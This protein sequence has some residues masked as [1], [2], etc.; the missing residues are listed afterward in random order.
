MIRTKF[1]KKSVIAFSVVALLSGCANKMQDTNTEKTKQGAL[2]GAVA[3][4]VLAAATGEGNRAKRAA[5]G[6]AAGAAV[7]GAIGYNMDKQAK[8]IAKS[9]DTDVSTSVEAEK[10]KDLDII[11]T[12]TDNYVKVTFR[13]KMM[14]ETNSATPTQ[15]AKFKISKFIKVLKNYPQSII[16]VV[17]HTDNRGTHAYNQTLSENRA[18]SVADLIM[19]SGIENKIYAKGCSFDKAIVPNDTKENMALNRRVEIFLYPNES[20][21]TNPCL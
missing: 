10:D 3:G 1:F 20:L 17:G 5:I 14:F 6:A 8:E 11:I 18:A 19:Q 13:D 4:A 21:I 12:K 2:I 16:Q 9:L 7:G 15:T